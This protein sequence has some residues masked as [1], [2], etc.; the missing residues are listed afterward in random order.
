MEALLETG[1]HLT[2]ASLRSVKLPVTAEENRT[3]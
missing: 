1:E 3:T 2:A